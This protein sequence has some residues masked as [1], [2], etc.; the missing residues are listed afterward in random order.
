MLGS[1]S[2]RILCRSTLEPWQK[3]RAPGP[4]LAPA[5]Q[6]FVHAAQAWLRAEGGLATREEHLERVKAACRELGP[7]LS[8]AHS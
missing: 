5:V 8:A 4:K 1:L 6:P 3:L 2:Q 7:Q